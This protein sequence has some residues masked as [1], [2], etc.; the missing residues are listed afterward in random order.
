MKTISCKSHSVLMFLFSSVLLLL[1]CG[2][3]SGKGVMDEAAREQASGK[4]VSLPRGVVHYELS[5]PP[6]AETV[7]MIH[8]FT[9]PYF[10]WDN[11]YHELVN[12]GFRV[13]R[14]DLFGRGYSDRP[15][16]IYDRDL[17][18]GQLFELLKALDIRKPVCLVG[19]SMGGA[20]SI[21]FSDRH[22]EQ[23]SKIGLIAPAG[24]QMKEPLSMKLVKAP[25]VG[26]LLMTTV[27]DRMVLKGIKSAFEKPDQLSE[28][29]EKFKVQMA[30]KGYTQAL[31]S[32]LRY[33]NM[34]DLGDVYDRVGEQKKPVLLIWGTNDKLLPLT[35][36]EKVMK[37]IPHLEFHAIDGA[38]HNLN[39]ETYQKVNPLLIE[40]LK[41]RR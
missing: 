13:L 30:Y 8:G 4:F 19:L 20:I 27:G 11:N 26:E 37:A 18:D 22:P 41:G 2:C 23:V 10:V 35:N 15:D 25:V 1:V 9:T 7:V 14:Y 28:F 33:M 32:T 5:G 24:Y 29:G 38:G 36:S 40:F 6:D 21:I 3:G 12:A 31:L 34:N 17:Y 39:Y 16:T